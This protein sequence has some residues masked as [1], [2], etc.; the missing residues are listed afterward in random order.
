[1]RKQK[2]QK[3]NNCLGP[4]GQPSLRRKHHFSLKFTEKRGFPSIWTSE[5]HGAGRGGCISFSRLIVVGGK[6]VCVWEGSGLLSEGGMGPLDGSPLITHDYKG[7]PGSTWP[8]D[9]IQVL[10][11]AL[12]QETV[13]SFTSLQ[14]SVTTTT[15]LRRRQHKLWTG[16]ID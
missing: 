16:G 7:A 2:A 3:N 14:T 8:V 9:T 5:A 13:C 1:M 11:E 4:L 10:L 15:H 12:T 6:R